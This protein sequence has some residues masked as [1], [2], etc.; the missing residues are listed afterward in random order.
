MA[1]TCSAAPCGHMPTGTG[2]C[3]V[4]TC[5][6]YRGDCPVHGSLGTGQ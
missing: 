1:S 6:N 4:V 2:H 5:E 3:N